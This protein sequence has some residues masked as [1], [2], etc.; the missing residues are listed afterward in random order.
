MQQAYLQAGAI[1]E[2]VK[3]LE[4]AEQKEI[5]WTTKDLLNLI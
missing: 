1:T 3:T 4:K 2:E 5:E